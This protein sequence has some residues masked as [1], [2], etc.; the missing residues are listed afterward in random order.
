[1]KIDFETWE[2]MQ[3]KLAEISDLSRCAKD[4]LTLINCSDT[5]KCETLLRLE[6]DRI[7]ELYAMIEEMEKE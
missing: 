3:K 6:E 1:M 7:D 4:V 5:A 2:K